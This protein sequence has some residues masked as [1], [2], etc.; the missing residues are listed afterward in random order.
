MKHIQQHFKWHFGQQ[1]TLAKRLTCFISLSLMCLS[2]T[3]NES[4]PGGSSN[5]LATQMSST[6]GTANVILATGGSSGTGGSMLAGSTGGLTAAGG[7]ISNT[8]G[9][10]TSG[11]ATSTGGTA[12]TGGTNTSSADAGAG[13]SNAHVAVPSA[14]CGMA[15][16]PSGGE[17]VVA[18]S[19]IYSFPSSY[20]GV[21]PMPLIMAFHAAGNNND[22]LRNIT[23]GSALDEHF[24][25]AFPKSAGNGW[26]PDTDG[27]SIDARY[28]ELR[29]SYC[30]DESRVFA[31]GHSSGAQLVVQLMCRGDER[32]A[33]IAPV[34]SSAYCA[35]WSNPIPSLIIHG[36]NDQERANT[37][38]DAD[39]TKDLAPY[40]LSN[41]C[42]ASTV[43]HAQAGCMSSGVQVEPGCVQ[44]QG[45]V[46]PTIW[47]QHNDPQY[48]N[49]NHGWPCFAND[50]I[51]TFLTSLP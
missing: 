11:G 46:E 5:T 50:A 2:C 33:A 40:L 22:Q 8:G 1:A 20:D 7:A 24:V 41:Q 29:A 35:S 6:G 23:R 27:A 30:I 13:E 37:N 42:G 10:T 34:A 26:S 4:P 31:T 48:S 43:A 14:G 12:V 17:V 18:G 45:C 39:G 25:M 16:R 32:F 44:Y 9:V 19:H 28:E 3:A 49:T 38:Q 47:C 51:D 15:G 21:T 36:A